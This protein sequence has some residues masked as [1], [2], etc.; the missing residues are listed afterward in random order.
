MNLLVTIKPG[1]NFYLKTMLLSLFKYHR[2]IKINV[3]LFQSFLSLEEVNDLSEFHQYFGHHL[4]VYHIDPAIFKNAPLYRGCSQEIY[5]RLLASEI[6]TDDIKRILY[7]DIDLI[8]NGNLEEL[9][10]TKFR[11]K[12]FVAC[13]DTNHS[14]INEEVYGILDIP[15]HYPYFNSGVLLM[16]LERLR[17]TNELERIHK[18]MSG[19]WAEKNKYFHDQNVLNALYYGKVKYVNSFVYNCLIK[20]FTQIEKLFEEC[21]I[22]HFAGIKPW[23]QEYPCVRCKEIWH[24]YASLVKAINAVNMQKHKSEDFFYGSI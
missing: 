20:N 23:E 12:Y 1:S 6:L 7:L 4:T 17:E 18:Y 22:F 24:K 13:E 14:M 2:N 11:G 15:M 3:H 10:Q 21:R 8:I 16:N 9:Y 19:D 5:Y